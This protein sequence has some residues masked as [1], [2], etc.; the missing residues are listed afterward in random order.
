MRMQYNIESAVAVF[1]VIFRNYQYT[2]KT[3][4]K[5]G[6]LEFMEQH[7]RDLTTT[8]RRKENYAHDT[9]KSKILTYS[10][11]FIWFGKYLI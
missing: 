5:T 11:R 4:D 7:R 3:I 9:I 10:C 8:L 1:Y 2:T 6:S